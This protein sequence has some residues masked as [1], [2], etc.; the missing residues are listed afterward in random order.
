[1]K[2]SFLHTLDLDHGDPRVSSPRHAPYPK[3]KGYQPFPLA[4]RPFFTRLR[5]HYRHYRAIQMSRF[6]S[7]RHAWFLARS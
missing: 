2:A 3:P 5:N 1:M 7:F 6:T 4:K